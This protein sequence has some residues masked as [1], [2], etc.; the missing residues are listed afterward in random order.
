MTDFIRILDTEVNIDA[1]LKSILFEALRDNPLAIAE[2]TTAANQP[3]VRYSFDSFPRGEAGNLRAFSKFG[4]GSA[5]LPS[6]TTVEFQSGTYNVRLM[7]DITTLNPGKAVFLINGEVIFETATSALAVEA[8]QEVEINKGD[9]ISIY[10][11]S[12]LFASPPRLGVY[13]GVNQDTLHSYAAF[14]APSIADLPTPV[15]V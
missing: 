7:K 15:N 3:Q 5:S 2:G 12:F 9:V 4:D 6:T 10:R 8:T 1:T 11:T 13:L 14:A